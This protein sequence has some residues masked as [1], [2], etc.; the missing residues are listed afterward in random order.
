MILSVQGDLPYSVEMTNTY[1]HSIFQITSD[2]DLHCTPAIVKGFRP[3][4]S[5]SKLSLGHPVLY[6]HSIGL[7]SLVMVKVF[8]MV[9]WSVLPLTYPLK[10]RKVYA[11]LVTDC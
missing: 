1:M 3:A 2:C 8:R 4:I 11:T 5:T 9:G 6:I 10:V 7:Q